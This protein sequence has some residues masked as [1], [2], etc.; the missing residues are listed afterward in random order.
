MVNYSLYLKNH[1]QIFVVGVG[2]EIKQFFK[3]LYLCLLARRKSN[4]N[5]NLRGSDNP[6][7][8]G[9]NSQNSYFININRNLSRIVNMFINKDI[10]EYK[11]RDMINS[12]SGGIEYFK[13]FDKICEKWLN[14]MKI[15]MFIL[16]YYWEIIQ[17]HQVITIFV[18]VTLTFHHRACNN[19]VVTVSC[20]I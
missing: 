20:R 15:V 3:S 8:I 14:F 1:S 19:S 12:L 10:K 11:N 6:L 9:E 2:K 18:V 4:A 5:L 7:K 17:L 16:K 13:I